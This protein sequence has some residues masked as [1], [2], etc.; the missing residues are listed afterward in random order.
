MTFCHEYVFARASI[1]SFDINYTQ[2][3]VHEVLYQVSLLA[4]YEQLSVLLK[5]EMFTDQY[6]FSVEHYS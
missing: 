4:F 3:F 1:Q 2:P 5:K 6:K